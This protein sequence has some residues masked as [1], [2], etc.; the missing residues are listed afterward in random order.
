LGKPIVSRP[1]LGGLGRQ[2]VDVDFDGGTITTDAGL[3]L[4]REVDR[5]LF[6][7]HTVTVETFLDSYK[8]PPSEIILGCDATDDPTY[9][10]RDQV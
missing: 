7:L 10:E 2:S 6:H 8:T 4:L 1:V 5:K 9:D 3:F